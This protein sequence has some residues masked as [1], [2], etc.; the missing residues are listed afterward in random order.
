MAPRT[1]VKEDNRKEAEQ[2]NSVGGAA[3]VESFFAEL[4]QA[5]WL[6]PSKKKATKVKVKP[7]VLKNEIWDVLEKGD[8]SFKSLLVLENLQILE[9]Y[10]V[11]LGDIRLWLIQVVTYGQ[12]IP[13]TPPTFML[14]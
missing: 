14:F 1:R 7:D 11:L 6:K 4:A 10:A 9:R 12:V 5:H 2:G 3:D 8:F 13:K